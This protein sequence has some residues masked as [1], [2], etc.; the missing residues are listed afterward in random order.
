[1]SDVTF[2]CIETPESNSMYRYIRGQSSIEF[3]IYIWSNNKILV[4]FQWAWEEKLRSRLK[5]SIRGKTLEYNKPYD[6]HTHSNLIYSFVSIFLYRFIRVCCQLQ[7]RRRCCC[8]WWRWLNESLIKGMYVCMFMRWLGI[9]F[10]N[11][12][13]ENRIWCVTGLSIIIVL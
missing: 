7:S 8:C 12:D 1:M 5:Q 11:N 9:Q 13:D 3:N 2:T 10:D 6:I 4:S